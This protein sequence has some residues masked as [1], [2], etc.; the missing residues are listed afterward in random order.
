ML[1]K[2]I[3]SLILLFDNTFRPD[4]GYVHSMAIVSSRFFFLKKWGVSKCFLFHC[5][6]HISSMKKEEEL[7][8][9]LNVIHE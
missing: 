8:I 2:V 9:K 7:F 1:V 6:M 3:D 5:N 4:F